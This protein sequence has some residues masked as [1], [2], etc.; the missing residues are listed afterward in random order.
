MAVFRKQRSGQWPDG[1]EF[2]SFF[3]GGNTEVFSSSTILN[4]FTKS[5]SNRLFGIS[6]DGASQM[7]AVL[8]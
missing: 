8:D 4:D 3:V 2:M 7:S 5:D 6:L 1:L